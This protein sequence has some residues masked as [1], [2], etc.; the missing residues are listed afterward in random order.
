MSNA[1]ITTLLTLT[2]H[3]YQPAASPLEF[4]VAQRDDFCNTLPCVAMQRGKALWNVS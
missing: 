3:T 4:R 2:I 1:V